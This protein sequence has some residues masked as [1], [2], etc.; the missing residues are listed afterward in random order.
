MS[1]VIKVLHVIKGLDRGG[2]ETGLIMLLQNIDRTRFQIDFLITVEKKCEYD[3][4]ARSLGARLINNPTP[5]RPLKYA[6]NFINN[7][8]KYGPYDIV[9]IHVHHYS[10]YVLLISKL[11]G[12]KKRIVHSRSD[13][14]YIDKHSGILRKI[15]LWVMKELIAK[16]ATHYIAVS[17]E[18]AESLYKRSIIE[19]KVV[20]ILPS[21]IDL[22]LFKQDVKKE[23]VRA[24]L[25]IPKNAT[26]IGHVGRFHPAK[27]HNLIINIALYL[28]TVKRDYVFLL[29]GEGQLMEEIKLKAR[30]LGIESNILFLGVR[31]DV[32]KLMMGAMDIF[33]FPSL[34][35]GLPVALIEAQAAALPCL[36]SNRITEE[37]DIIKPLIFRLD[38]FD[39]PLKWV[40]KILYVTK[41][42]PLVSSNY[43]IDK[44]EKSDF[45]IVKVARRIKVIY[46]E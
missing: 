3:D 30:N 26:V 9:H 29:I 16:Y 2:P 6:V 5:H 23:D 43:I 10:G 39:S 35:E 18:A 44:L 22:S 41:N 46:D 1:S 45:N 31:R 38:P 33:L 8:R 36:I 40:G 7:N 14:R 17:K 28:L 20:H 13:T 12:I 21:G 42:K 4:L 19:K 11:C 32:P 15:Y 24:E 34:Y 37:V 27:N 25:G